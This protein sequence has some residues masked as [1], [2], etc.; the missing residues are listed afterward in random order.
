[1]S[2]LK[3]SNLLSIVSYYISLIHLI[4]QSITFLLVLSNYHNFLY[5]LINYHHLNPLELFKGIISLNISLL[6]QSCFKQ[7]SQRFYNLIH[8]IILNKLNFQYTLTFPLPKYLFYQRVYQPLPQN[9][10]LILQI[11]FFSIFISMSKLAA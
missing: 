10:Q 6:I 4:I 2:Y 5:L 3:H 7:Y 1:M 11:Y 9:E 8:M